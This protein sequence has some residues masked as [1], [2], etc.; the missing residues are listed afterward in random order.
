MNQ[1]KILIVDDE[2]QFRRVMRAALRLR[3]FVV[4]EAE[5]GEAASRRSATRSR[6]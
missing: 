3:G 6:T 2:M 1:E 4:D 5:N